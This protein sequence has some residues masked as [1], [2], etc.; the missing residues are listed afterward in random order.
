MNLEVL[1]GRVIADD[2]L[3]AKLNDLIEIVEV[4][5]PEGKVIGRFVPEDEFQEM[6]YARA[7]Q[8]CPF[9]EEELERRSK[10]TEGSSLAEF[11]KRMGR[12]Y[13]S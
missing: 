5:T 12:T 10:E 4:A 3:R 13:G 9:S 8:S 7:I 1:M 2:G 6:Q 11:W